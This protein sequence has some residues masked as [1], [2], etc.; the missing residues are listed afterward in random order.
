MKRSLFVCRKVSLYS[1]CKNCYRVNDGCDYSGVF[2]YRDKSNYNPCPICSN[3]NT[4]IC[5]G[6]C[7]CRK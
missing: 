2:K 5:V 1:S 6:C 4:G 3:K 7:Y